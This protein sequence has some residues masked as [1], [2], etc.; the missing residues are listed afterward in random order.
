MQTPVCRRVFYSF[1]LCWAVL[2]AGMAQAQPAQTQSSPAAR[3]SYSA[4][5]RLQNSEIYD[6][7]AKEWAS[8]LEKFPND[9]LAARAQHYL[10]VCLYKSNEF[11]KA[12]AAFEKVI[13]TYPKFEFLEATYYFLA[14]SQYSQALKGKPELFERARQSFAALAAAYPKGERLADALFYQGECYYSQDKLA[15]A[16]GLYSQVAKAAPKSPLVAEALYAQGIAQQKLNQPQAA[17][18]TYAAFLKQFPRHAHTTEV[19]MR[20][21]E[22][23]LAQGS[24]AEAERLLATAAATPNFKLAD[25]ALMQQAESAFQQKKYT[26]AAALFA[27]LPAKFPKSESISKAHVAAGKS[28]YLAGKLADARTWLNKSLQAGDADSVEAAHWIA[29]SYLKEQKPAEALKMVEASLPKAANSPFAAALQLDRADALYELP[30]RRK[31]SIKAYADLAAKYPQDTSAPQA[32]YMAAFASLGLED[33][34]GALQHAAAFNKSYANHALATDVKHVEAESQLLLGQHAEAERLYKQLLAS[35]PN[36]A[37]AAQWKIRHALALS[38]Q[39]KHAETVAA[40]ESQLPSLARPEQQAEARYLIGAS[41]SELKQFDAAAKS[42]EAS[43]KASDSWRQAD[44]ATLLLA[45]AYRQL[46]KLPEAVATA[47][48]LASGYPQSK[49]L[50]Q[51]HYRWGE[52]AYAAGDYKTAAAQYQ[53]VLTSWPQSPLAVNALYGLG[54]SQFSTN[55]YAAAAKSFTTLVQNYAKDPLVP[56]AQYARGLA[57]HQIKEHAGA[58]DDLQAF[59]AT[60]PSPPDKSDARYILGLCQTNAKQEEAA[61]ATFETLLKEDPQYAKADEVLYELAWTQKSL[62]QQADAAATFA[63]LAE[64]HPNSRHAAES[65]FH[66][67]EREYQQEKFDKAAVAYHAATTKA[68][69]NTDLKE[70]A[71]HKLAWAYY[72]QD[73]FPKAQQTFAYQ[74][75]TFKNGKLAADA[76]FME[77]ESLFKQGKYQEAL[78]AYEQVKDPST[79]DFLTLALLHGGQSAGQLKQWP[80]SVE[81]LDRAAKQ[82]SEAFLPEILYEQGWAKQNLGRADEAIALYEAVTT[83]TNAEVAARARFM[84]GE[85]Y[86]EKKDHKEALRNFFK[87]AYGYGYPYWQANAHYEAA[88]CLEVLQLPEQAKKSYEEIVQKFPQSDKAALAQKRLREL[89]G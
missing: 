72:R 51:A 4:A 34:R 80:K 17:A 50:D 48:K 28:Y 29:R 63:R 25:L 59:L 35:Q 9:P 61:I 11:E 5:E 36:H 73:D 47:R 75:S 64:K 74:R 6:T 55:D 40:L 69:D 86:F 82:A 41:Q 67:G 88:R 83:K 30:E 38:L 76:A 43:L 2:A 46:N 79:P 18:D 8:F 3:Q 57:R 22:A 58:I 89:G 84:I 62:D 44:A 32:A 87:C 33:Y 54:W 24:Y 1:A 71:T 37:E 78:A 10:G 70:K 81:L 39:K 56:R 13:K 15:E 7:A 68:G 45:Q 26:E 85:I 77:G 12:Q 66:V 21:G 49:L 31:E 65:L 23:L 20:R 60:N 19:T 16:I 14:L 27:S 52:Y 53:Q 42:L